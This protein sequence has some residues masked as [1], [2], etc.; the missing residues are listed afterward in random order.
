MTTELAGI[1]PMSTVRLISNKDQMDYSTLSST[2]LI[3]FKVLKPDDNENTQEISV[4]QIIE[5][6]DTLIKNKY[7][8]GI[9]RGNYTSFIDENHGF[10]VES[11]NKIVLK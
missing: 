2:L 3:S 6:L 8:T 1:V 9:S 7:I 4:A 10:T 5:N 11:K